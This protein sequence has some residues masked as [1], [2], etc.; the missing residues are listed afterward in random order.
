MPSTGS[1]I[2]TGGIIIW[3]G[4]TADIPMGW[5]ICDGTNGTPDLRDRFVVGAGSTYAV[6]VTGGATTVNLQHN[7]GGATGGVSFGG[8]GSLTAGALDTTHT[9]SISNDL[10][11]TQSILPPYYALTYI[12]KS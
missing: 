1:E 2:P 6:G 12:M 4:A 11:T 5:F 8:G 10:S 9:H 3:S 7:H